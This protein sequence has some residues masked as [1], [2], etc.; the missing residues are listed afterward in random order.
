MYINI[1]N[2]NPKNVRFILLNLETKETD[3]TNEAKTEEENVENLETKSEEKEVAKSEEKK[4]DDSKKPET[5]E[6]HKESLDVVREHMMDV[7]N[8]VAQCDEKEVDVYDYDEEA[9]IPPKRTKFKVDG[10]K[11]SLSDSGEFV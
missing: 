2:T 7:I 11:K 5:S 1:V 6:K 10:A 8:C 4:E 9:V 3:K